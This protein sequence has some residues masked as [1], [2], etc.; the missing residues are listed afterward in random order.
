MVVLRPSYIYGV[1]DLKNYSNVIG[2]TLA[3]VIVICYLGYVLKSPYAQVMPDWIPLG[4]AHVK[5]LCSAA[6]TSAKWYCTKELGNS[7]ETRVQLFNIDDPS[8]AS[9]SSVLML[10][11]A[12][13]DWIDALNAA[14]PNCVCKSE[15]TTKLDP[16]F[17][18]S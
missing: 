18:E 8:H 3:N 9:K 2:L 5:D 1:G 12:A 7:E 17:L 4:V 10:S 13:K 11:S 6:V 15:L 14:M 16:V